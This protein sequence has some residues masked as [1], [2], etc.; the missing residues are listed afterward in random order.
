M[1]VQFR[2]CVIKNL[3]RLYWTINYIQNYAKGVMQVKFRS[4]YF[5][6]TLIYIIIIGCG[7]ILCMYPPNG[8]TLFMFDVDIHSYSLGDDNADVSATCAYIIYDMS[9]YVFN[10]LS[11][12]A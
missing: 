4:K 6:L 9:G 8:I 5:Y 10:N 2:G 3:L 7:T 11:F 12:T 1:L